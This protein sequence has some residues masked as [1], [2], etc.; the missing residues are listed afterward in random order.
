MI[1]KLAIASLA[2]FAAMSVLAQTLIGSLSGVE[3]L[4][5]VLRGGQLSTAANAD[6][7]AVGDRIIT[8]SSGKVT[9]KFDKKCDITLKENQSIAIDEK[10]DCAALLASVQP[11][12]GTPPPGVT[13]V[14]SGAGLDAWLVGGGVVLAVVL[15]RQG[16]SGR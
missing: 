7:F 5:T 2:V 12:G 6:R 3:G 11:V 8:T 9:L 13:P 1:K 10:L 16:T 4:V 14:A 15:G